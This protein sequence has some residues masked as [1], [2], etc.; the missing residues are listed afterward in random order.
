ME[1]IKLKETYDFN[2]LHNSK[3][4]IDEIKNNEEIQNQLSESKELIRKYLIDFAQS[5]IFN[6]TTVDVYLSDS[7]I[8]LIC[9]NDKFLKKHYRKGM[10]L[11]EVIT[12]F[13]NTDFCK[14]IPNH[15][16]RDYDKPEYPYNENHYKFNEYFIDVTNKKIYFCDSKHIWVFIENNNTQIKIELLNKYTYTWYGHSRDSGRVYPTYNTDTNN[17]YIVEL[18]VDI[19]TNQII[20][21]TETDD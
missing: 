13:K 7:D 2:E 19:Q 21:N 8:M 10:Q 4:V 18:I 15:Y 11:S 17:Y 14:N 20:K 3:H 12:L 6:I 1:Q 5:F 16:G 9:E